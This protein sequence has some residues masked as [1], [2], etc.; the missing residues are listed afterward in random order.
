M[1]TP[2]RV[3]AQLLKKIYLIVPLNLKHKSCCEPK[4]PHL[5]IHPRELKTHSPKNLHGSVHIS[6][7]DNTVKQKEYERLLRWLSMTYYIY[8]IKYNSTIKKEQRAGGGHG[9]S[10]P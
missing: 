7:I 4:I 10:E 3:V 6:I 1:Y 9:G 5:G 2:Y 8:T